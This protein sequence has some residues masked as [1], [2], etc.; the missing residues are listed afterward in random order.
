M[1]ERITEDE[2]REIEEDHYWGDN[3]GDRPRLV[4]EV[5]RLRGL[6]A[7]CAPA[8]VTH[9]EDPAPRDDQILE[10]IRADAAIERE[11]RAIREETPHTKSLG[12]P[13]S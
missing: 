11:A 7:A 2:L 1:S 8:E 4:A 3:D 13:A 9:L 5:R 12:R 10:R 6:I